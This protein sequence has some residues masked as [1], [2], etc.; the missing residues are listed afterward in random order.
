MATKL[1][2][3]LCGENPLAY[4]EAEHVAIEAMNARIDFWNEVE[5]KL[6]G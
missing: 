1:V 6:F 2:E 5:S 4:V 3:N